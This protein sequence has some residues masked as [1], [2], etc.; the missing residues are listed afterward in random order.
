MIII[1]VD[2]L[3]KIPFPKGYEALGERWHL[4]MLPTVSWQIVEAYDQR[5]SYGVLIHNERGEVVAFLSSL[6]ELD[7]L[8]AM[9]EWC[10]DVL[11]YWP[12]ISQDMIE[13]WRSIWWM[14]QTVMNQQNIRQTQA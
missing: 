3:G 2:A 10:M 12:L 5:G 14:I 11:S 6:I 1:N 4:S 8:C 7:A 9:I 13:Q